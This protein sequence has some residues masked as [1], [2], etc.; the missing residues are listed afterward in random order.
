MK[1]HG[2]AFL[3]AL[4]YSLSA[5]NIVSGIESMFRSQFCFSTFSLLLCTLMSGSPSFNA[6]LEGKCLRQYS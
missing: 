1:I 5:M 4:K 2:S 3:R 6:Y